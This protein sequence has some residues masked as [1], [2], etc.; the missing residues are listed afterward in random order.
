MNETLNAWPH[1]AHIVI[2]PAKKRD[3]AIFSAAILALALVGFGCKPV[4]QYF[5]HNHER[6]VLLPQMSALAEQGK[7][8]A[9]IWMLKNSSSALSAKQIAVLQQAAEKGHPQS[10][11]LYAR[12]LQIMNDAVGAKTWFERAAGEGYP[13]AILQLSK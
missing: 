4:A 6:D 13:E 9:V 10:M 3:L 12:A 2:N 7:P 5:I 8:E 1:K 11:F